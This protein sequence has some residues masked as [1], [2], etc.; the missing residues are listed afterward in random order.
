MRKIWIVFAAEIRKQQQ[1]NY[2]S[3]FVWFS[4]L[5][6]PI[7]G[8]LEVYYTY[9]PFSLEGNMVGIHD[10]RE[11][12]AFLA[13][14]YM[15]YNCFWSMVQNAWSMSCDERTGGTLEMEFLSPAN[16]LAMNYGKAMGA[17]LQEVWMFSCFCGFVLIYTGRIRMNNWYLLPAVFALLMVASAILGGML[18]AVFLL[19]RDASIAM[20]V[21]DTPMI[22]F[23]GTRIPV[24]GFPL[25]A[26]MISV[27]FPLTY[28]LNIIRAV[29]NI[30]GRSQEWMWDLGRLLICLG[31]MI[32]ITIWILSRAEKRNRRTG[33]LLFY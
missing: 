22:L 29:L 12:L 1:H 33:E 20:N 9:K 24:D 16:R 26:R 6:W 21:L 25:W 31:I 11:L 14:G 18:N 8:F 17:L 28:C 7:L 4:L 32:G 15:A 2:H 27:L 30:A 10:S 13:S 3:Y 23:S 5:I 19:S